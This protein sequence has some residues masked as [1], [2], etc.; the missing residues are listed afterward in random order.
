MSIGEW[1]IGPLRHPF[2][3]DLVPSCSGQTS[4]QFF[5]RVLKTLQMRSRVVSVIG[6]PASICCQCLAETTKPIMSRG[7]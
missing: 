3:D 7:V 4:N 5:H 6:Q 1:K 2:F